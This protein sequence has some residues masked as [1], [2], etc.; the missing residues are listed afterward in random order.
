MNDF[1]NQDLETKPANTDF[2]AGQWV[3]GIVSRISP[4]GVNVQVDKDTEG[5]LYREE[6]F[7]DIDVGDQVKVFIKNVREDGKLDLSLQQGG[8]KH[9][10]P[11]AKNSILNE[12]K[13]AGGFLPFH[14]K[15]SPEAIQDKFHISK[16]KFSILNHDLY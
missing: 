13:A 8:Y 10:V 9:V 2:K 15:T 6:I 5:L 14:D 11:D 16:K 7:Q 12:L 3:R 4:L 1:I